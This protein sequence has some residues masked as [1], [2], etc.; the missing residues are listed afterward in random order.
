MKEKLLFF[1]CTLLFFFNTQFNTF[2]LI[3]KEAFEYS[4]IEISEALVIGKLLNTEQNSI[5]ADGGFTGI[6]YSNENFNKRIAANQSYKSYL[7]NEIPQKAIYSRYTSQ[8]GGQ[9]ILYSVFDQTFDLDNQ[10]NLMFFSGFNALALSIILSFFIIWIKRKFGLTVASISFIL[11]LKNYWIFLYGKSIWWC[12]WVYF[13]PFVYALFFFENSKSTQPNFI[14][15]SVA[16]ASFFFLKFWF[17]GFEFITVFLICSAVPYIYYQF[18]NNYSFYLNFIKR[19]FLIFI[20]PFSLAIF[21]QLYQFK[22]LT[23]NFN[24]GIQHLLDAYNKRSSSSY[25]Y[26]TDQELLNTLKS[27]HLDIITRYLGNSF[28]NYDFI[29]IKLPFLIIIG[30]GVICSFFLYRKN[31][32]RRLVLTTWFSITAPLSWL[33]LFKQHAHI[34]PHIDFFVWYCPFLLL[35]IVLISLTIKNLLKHHK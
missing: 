15:Y 28:I 27:F 5:M 14:K 8:I 21:I 1:I 6:Y 13:L 23:G 11:I 30:I 35:L 9:A 24:N 16:M 10:T 33:I 29:G 34:H 2:H 31:I 18:Q 25:G 20:V 26:P 3:P 12:S 7:N 19:H 32:E 4:K 17:T 22:L